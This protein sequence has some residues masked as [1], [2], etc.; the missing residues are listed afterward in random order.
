MTVQLSTTVRNAMGDAIEIAVG[1]SPVLKIRVGAQPASVATADSGTVL[2]TMALP[3]DWQAAAS[4]GAK[5]L[6]GVWQ[7]LT[8]D[9]SGDAGHWRVYASDGTTCHAQGGVG[10]TG[11]TNDLTLAQL[12]AAI[13][14]G[15][16]VSIASFTLTMPGA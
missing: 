14:G 16:L 8:A 11:A 5:A 10:Y 7:D 9:A 6:L 15:Q 2:A 4:G 1:T 12:S 3:S 13:V